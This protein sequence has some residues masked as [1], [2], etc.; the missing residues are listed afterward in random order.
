LAIITISAQ[1]ARSF[2][3]PRPAKNRTQTITQRSHLKADRRFRELST[4]LPLSDFDQKLLLPFNN[5]QDI[6]L[7][8][9]SEP[10]R[11][12]QVFAHVSLPILFIVFS[13]TQLQ[14][15]ML[16]RISVFVEENHFSTDGLAT[17]PYEMADGHD[18][19]GTDIALFFSR[20]KEDGMPL[21]AEEERL[22]GSLVQA[23]YLTTTPNGDYRETARFALASAAMPVD[24]ATLIHELCHMLY[25]TDATY[26]SRVQR[27]WQTLPEQLQTKIRQT[28]VNFG[29]ASAINRPDIL[30]T[31]FAAY[32][33][34]PRSFKD[35]TQKLNKTN[36][37]TDAELNML[38]Q[39]LRRLDHGSP[40]LKEWHFKA[41][42][43]TPIDN[44]RE[45]AAVTSISRKTSVY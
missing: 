36:L 33:R 12:Y 40:L 26:A 37:F 32:F 35:V 16:D 11:L 29:Y 9:A 43:A 15:L 8:M 14:D 1:T 38:R 4:S 24:R 27:S 42:Q 18:L 34:D 22:L 41:H 7:E 31:E 17:H 21:T 20:M 19:R 13:E 2:E 30:Y 44:N 28:I 10:D 3:Q 5:G 45:K 6:Q 25:M 39:R 23:G